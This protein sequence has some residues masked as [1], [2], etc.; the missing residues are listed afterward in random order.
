M[1]T[2]V[3]SGNYQL[4]PHAIERASLRGI[5][6]LEIKKALICGKVIEVYPED[7]R[8][9]SCLVYGKTLAGKDLHMVCGVAAGLLRII[10]VYEPN[11]A[12]WI[13][14]KTRR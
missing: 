4:R 8:R 9:E 2:H 11:P 12:E 10:T 1:R 7:P 6:P 3:H 5:D 14:A 13:D